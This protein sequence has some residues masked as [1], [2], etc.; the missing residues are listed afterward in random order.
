[1]PFYRQPIEIQLYYAFSGNRIRVR[2]ISRNESGSWPEKLT[3]QPTVILE[4]SQDISPLLLPAKHPEHERGADKYHSK[5]D[6][7]EQG[8]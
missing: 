6:P 4:P 1:M 8:I 7:H 2:L 5:N 3:A